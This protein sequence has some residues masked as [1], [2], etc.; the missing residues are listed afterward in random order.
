MI[1]M[2]GALALLAMLSA[3]AVSLVNASIEDT[4]GQHAGRHQSQVVDAA[5]RY[6]R[7]HY[8][9]LAAAS[10]GGPVA[11]PVATLADLLPA[12]FQPANAFGQTP[13]VRVLQAAPGRLNAL[14]VGEGGRSIPERDVAY[15]AAHAGRGGGQVAA[16][17]PGIAQGVFG[18]W[19]VA[20]A[21][22]EAVTCGAAGPADA[23]SNRLA[24]ALFFDGPGTAAVDF[25]YRREVPGH[26]EL[27]ALEV[28]VAMQGRAVVIQD[29]ATDPLCSA[30]DPL[31]S[32]R[33]AV[34]ADGAVLSCQAGT[35]RRQ[36]SAYW[37]D[38]VA[39]A[40]LL[41]ALD[42]QPGDVRLTQDTSRAF[43]WN[44][45]AW[46]ALAVDETGNLT[47]PNAILLTNWVTRGSACAPVGAVS[48][49]A[50]GL[51]VSC[52]G[53]VWKTLS[54]TEVDPAQS[55]IGSSVI[56][57]SGY[58]A[59]PGGTPFY[60]GPFAYDA[61][62]DTMMATIER[63]VMPTKD[64]LI[65]SNASVD[66]S[67]GTINTPDDTGNVNLIVQVIDRD[68]GAVLAVNQ[69]RQTKMVFDRAIL[70]VTLSKAVPRNVN[71]YT[72]Q[73]LVRWSRRM[74]NYAS[75]FYD[76]ANYLDVFGNVVE[77]TPIQLNWNFDLTY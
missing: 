70:A 5:E 18:S 13:C 67:V 31:A 76:R 53:G 20:T 27:N 46:Q 73:M 26:P 74:N 57:R 71:G 61:P 22:Y 23:A 24:S 37:K 32:G 47:V 35:W 40:A 36:G 75:N 39:T 41:P 50:D 63:P 10:A 66:M 4:R 48:R 59:Y 38:P 42:N 44:G 51:T 68:T 11:V 3:G 62:N 17:D 58:M 8:A 64:G 16:A 29:D 1:E 43:A 77:L 12:G 6:I 54:A 7:D 72:F 19:R 2:L 60:G 52:Q 25:L 69:A 21:P 28:P 9:A 14:V 33:I 56:L 49:E 15:V 34:G 45:A 65:I 55:E 30:A